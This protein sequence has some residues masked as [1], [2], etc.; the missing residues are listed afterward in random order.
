MRPYK[1][2]SCGAFDGGSQEDEAV[3]L[4]PLVVTLLTGI[5]IATQAK[6]IVRIGIKL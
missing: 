1:C 2:I 6:K 4:S 5:V 3:C